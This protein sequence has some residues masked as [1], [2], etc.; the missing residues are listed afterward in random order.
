MEEID[1]LVW[2]CSLG[3]CSSLMVEEL[4]AVGDPRAD[5]RAGGESVAS[6]PNLEGPSE[7][8]WVPEVVKDLRLTSR[9][10]RP[11]LPALAASEVVLTKDA[12]RKAGEGDGDKDP[13]KYVKNIYSVINCL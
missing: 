2:A 9:D 3:D 5:P 8:R 4:S 11:M 12:R 7:R 10:M 6:N 1:R 13:K